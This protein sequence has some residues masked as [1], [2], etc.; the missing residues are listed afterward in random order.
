MN[1]NGAG[2]LERLALLG[3]LAGERYA[4]RWLAMGVRP[5]RVYDMALWAC[6]VPLHS[7]GPVA[8]AAQHDAYHEVVIS[9]EAEADYI[10]RGAFEDGLLSY[11]D[12]ARFDAASV[13]AEEPAP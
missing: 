4:E 9:D 10:W 13:G 2:P 7:W 12:S 8:S 5:S 3:M 6:G 1:E 11:L